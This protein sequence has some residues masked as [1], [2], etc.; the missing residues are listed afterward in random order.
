MYQFAQATDDLTALIGHVGSFVDWWGDVN[1]SLA[2]LEGILPQ[3]KVDS[4]SLFR[5]ET[6]AERWNGVHQRYVWYQREV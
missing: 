1:M 4:K 5:T 2:N 3:V 6:V